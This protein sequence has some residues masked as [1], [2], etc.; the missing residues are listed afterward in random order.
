MALRCGVC[1]KT[2]HVNVVCHHCGMPLC[3]EHKLEHRVRK[4]RAFVD[5][6]YRSRKSLVAAVKQW[7]P[8]GQ[9]PEPLLVYHCKKC[10][11]ENH[12]LI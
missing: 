9:Q 11:G 8:R 3:D 12:R 5:H 10:K 6:W 1:S 2:E 4:D 7:W